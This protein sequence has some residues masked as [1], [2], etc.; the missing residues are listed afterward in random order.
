VQSHYWKLVWTATII[1]YMLVC[2]QLSADDGTLRRPFTVNDAIEFSHIVDFS[3]T[4]DSRSG[5][6]PI[7]SPDKKWFVLITTKGI[8]SSNKT[9][10]IIWL[11]S[12]SAVTDYVLGK[13]LHCPNPT[14]IV[15]LTSS[16][17][18]PV[19][20]GLRWLSDSNQ[21]TFLGLDSTPYQRLFIYNLQSA[22]LKALSPP[23]S[24]VTGYDVSGNTIAYTSV[25]D[26][27]VAAEPAEPLISVRNRGLW[28]LLYPN[29][30]SF[31]DLQRGELLFASTVHVIKNGHELPGIVMDGKPLRVF[32][33]A[34]SLAPPLSVSP[35]G[36]FLITVGAVTEIPAKWNLYEPWDHVFMDR[37]NPTDKRYLSEDNP[38]KPLQYILIDLVKAR[39]KPLIAAPIGRNLS[40]IAPLKTFWFPDSRRVV[41]TNTFV[42]FDV[43]DDKAEIEQKSKS[44]A[45]VFV[46]IGTNMQQVV[47]F[48]HQ[49]P[50]ASSHDHRIKDIVWTP[51]GPA[52][53]LIYGDYYGKRELERYSYQ[54][55]NWNIESNPI[56]GTHVPFPD[57]VELFIDEHFDRPPTLKGKKRNNLTEVMIWDPN[58]QLASLSLGA[59]SLYHWKDHEGTQWAGLLALPPDYDH[60]HRYPLVIQTHGYDPDSYFVD[61]MF[62]TGHPGRALSAKGIVV[63][64][65]QFPDTKNLFTPQDAPK[66]M[67]GF[68]SAI[69]QLAADGLIDKQRV[70]IIG[71]SYTCFHT[72]YTLVHNPTLVAAASISDG[73]NWSY[74]Q[75][76][77][78]S[79]DDPDESHWQRV[80]EQVN[81]G[82]PWGSGLIMW[83]QR[84]PNFNLDKVTTPLLI[85][86]LERRELLAMWEPYAGLRRLGRPV[87]MLWLRKEDANH[88]VQKPL[89]KFLS[90][91]SAVD[92]FDFWL[93]GRRD[94]DPRKNEQYDRWEELRHMRDEQANQIS[95]P[96]TAGAN[97]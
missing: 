41:I 49:S 75:Y 59:I 96:E 11:F 20:S 44:P 29:R 97:Q 8:L 43:G 94:P 86:A 70:G 79:A 19:I 13:S 40:H 21:V 57:P 25:L 85:S 26:E 22:S 12:R 91:Q 27:S 53:T 18:M 4:D 81:G 84:S 82:M 35:D 24:Y 78:R 56:V 46:D 34:W 28:S 15:S 42:P 89:H 5:R 10:S 71:F 64:Q 87:D 45:V 30:P 3:A 31:D 93:N 62:S 92:W 55:G 58:P 72:L 50:H 80:S 36:R 90:Q 52:I 23:N 65:M 60:R 6:A 66:A 67:E 48:F 9:E 47:T 2:T 69:A 63:L 88:V 83:A 77:L 74:S 54:S 17:N 51:D 16:S 32:P 61:G 33:P 39:A 95:Q 76:L 14:P 1:G 37:L 38:Y 7:D 68:E 73:N